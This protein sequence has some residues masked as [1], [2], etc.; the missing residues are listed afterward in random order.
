MLASRGVLCVPDFIAN[1]GGVICA[2]VEWRGGS[3]SEAF[4]T[5]DERIRA[6]TLEL[7]DR[8]DATDELPRPA[9]ESMARARLTKAQGF[10]R[11]F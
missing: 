5:I 6:N 2:A 8:M 9:A 11:T 4:A 10:R 1:A 7:L 3:R